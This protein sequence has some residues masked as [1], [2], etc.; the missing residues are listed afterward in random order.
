MGDEEESI[1]KPA[2]NELRRKG[3]DIT[4]PLPS[5]TL[6]I[7]AGQNYLKGEKAPYDCYIAGSDQIWHNAN[8]FRY[9][10][11][12]PD[13]KLKLSYAASFGKAEISDDRR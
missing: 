5:D 4:D 9:L 12:V 2:V 1:I 13:N 3:I 11:Y 7:K 6:F 8:N 10:T